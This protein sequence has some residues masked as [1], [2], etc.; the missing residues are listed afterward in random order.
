MR[1]SWWT[2]AAWS[3]ESSGAGSPAARDRLVSG[4]ATVVV[5]MGVTRGLM[6][7]LAW[8]TVRS[9]LAAERIR[10]P[11]TAGH[12]AGRAVRDPLSA[13]WETEVIRRVTLKATGG[14]TYGEL[15]E[16]DPIARMAMESSLLRSSLFTSI[17]AFGVAAAE[18]AQGVALVVIGAALLRVD[19]R[20][21][22]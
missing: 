19:R 15:D 6:G 14:R 1:R 3:G 8:L 21:R 4:L 18:M 7:L 20:P 17:L 12:L 11:D 16:D 2:D 5:G 13:F 22:S 9:Q 10:I